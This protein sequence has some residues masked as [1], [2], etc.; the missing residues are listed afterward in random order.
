MI[1]GNSLV[2]FSVF[3][4]SFITNLEAILLIYGL[5]FGIG[6]GISVIFIQ[7]TSPLTISWS[8]FPCHKG[9]ISGIIISGFG[10]GSAIFNIVATV[11]I[12]P[13]NEKPDEE[14]HDV[15]YFK[16]SIAEDFPSMLRWLSLIY[17]TI[18]VLGVFLLSY[19]IHQREIAEHEHEHEHQ[20]RLIVKAEAVEECPSAIIGIKTKEFWLLFCM[21]V[22]SVT[23]G[24]YVI[25]SYKTFGSKEINNDEFLAV[26]GSVS[27]VFNGIFRYLWGQLMD[28]TSFKISYAILICTQTLLVMTLYYVVSVKALYFIW[29]AVI[30]CCEG[31]HFSLFPTIVAKLFGKV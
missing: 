21:A 4:T 3:I 30:F 2:V 1:I 29:V 16:A 31:G 23:P 17:L 7:Y 28:K 9:R 25:N 12:N 8:H 26:V 15:K 24:L 6:V 11:I 13:D 22:C 5:L 20:E 10:F 27:S 18:S 14:Y 19:S